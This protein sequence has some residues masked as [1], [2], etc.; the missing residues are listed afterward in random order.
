MHTWLVF[1]GPPFVQQLVGNPEGLCYG[2][3]DGHCL[4][5][6]SVSMSFR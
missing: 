4:N 2:I 3:N 1:E 6:K 5:D